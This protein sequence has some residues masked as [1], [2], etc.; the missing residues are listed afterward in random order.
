M[1]SPL[2]TVSSIWLCLF[3]QE[4]LVCGAFPRLMRPEGGRTGPRWRTWTL[5]FGRASRAGS[6]S[7]SV[8]FRYSPYQSW[9]PTISDTIQCIFPPYYHCITTISSFRDSSTLRLPKR[10]VKLKP[11]CVQFSGEKWAAEHLQGFPVPAAQVVLRA[12]KPVQENAYGDC[13]K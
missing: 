1:L 4:P 13:D 6:L 8:M 9:P 5:L 7:T 12:R 10:K 11:W 3:I 2:T